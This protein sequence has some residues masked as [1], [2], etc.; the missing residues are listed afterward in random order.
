MRCLQLTENTIN[1]LSKNQVNSEKKNVVKS[2][3]PIFV[4]K[5]A[6]RVFFYHK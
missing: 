6:L 4:V 2:T 5:S 1:K 3:K